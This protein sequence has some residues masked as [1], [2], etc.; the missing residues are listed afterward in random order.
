MRWI[1][2]LFLLAAAYD[3][4]IGAA[5]VGFGPQLFEWAGVPPPNHWGY[6]EFAALMLVIF[7]VM[8]FEIATTSAWCLIIGG[9][10]AFPGSSSRSR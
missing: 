9:P 7:G 1:R 5:F 10:R 8:F 4:L 3:F 6:I 2:W